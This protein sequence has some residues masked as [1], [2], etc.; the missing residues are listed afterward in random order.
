M[1]RQTEAH[2]IIIMGKF[3]REQTNKNEEAKRESTTN[4]IKEIEIVIFSTFFRFEIKRHI[5]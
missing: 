4:K 1:Q 3:E 2:D 5:L